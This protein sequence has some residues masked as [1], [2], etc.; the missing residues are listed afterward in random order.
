MPTKWQAARL[1]ASASG[2][3]SQ[4]RIDEAVRRILTLKFK[5]GLFDQPCM[6]DTSKPCVNADAANAAVEAGRP[7][8]LQGIPGVDHPAAEQEQ[9]A[10]AVPPARS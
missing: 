2:A 10:A 6:R 5:L 9:R 1:L 7:A 4:A 3:I 8:A